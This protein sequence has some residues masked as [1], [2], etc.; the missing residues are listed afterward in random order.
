MSSDCAT[1]DVVADDVADAMNCSNGAPSNPST[2]CSWSDLKADL[3]L[4]SLRQLRYCLD[5]AFRDWY[6]L[7]VIGR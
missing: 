6:L 2:T 5:V 3:G 1:M 7:S 4:Y